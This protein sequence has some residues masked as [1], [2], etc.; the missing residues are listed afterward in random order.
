MPL[1]SGRSLCGTD[2]CRRRKEDMTM[3]WLM[4]LGCLLMATTGHAAGVKVDWTDNSENAAAFIIERMLGSCVAR[5]APRTETWTPIGS[6]PAN[7]KTYSDPTAVAGQ[8]YCYRVGARDTG[9]NRYYH[10]AE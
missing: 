8:I 6:T 10:L 5:G 1:G 2:R 7:V 3:R 4:T 9:G